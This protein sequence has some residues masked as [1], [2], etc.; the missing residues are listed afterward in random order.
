MGTLAFLLCLSLQEEGFRVDGSPFL[1]LGD[2]VQLEAKCIPPD[3]VVVWRLADGPVTSIETRPALSPSGHTVKGTSVLTVL[4]TGAADAEF[5]FSVTAERKGIRVATTEV[6]LRAGALL[7]IKVWCR[8][9][10]NDAGGTR[11][12]NLILDDCQR[13]ALQWNVNGLLRPLGVE[14]TLEAGS[15]LRGPDWWFD[16]QG[17]FQPIVMKDG[18]K[19]NSPSLND[20]ARNDLPGG[21][22]VY[23]VRDLYWEQVREGFEREVTEHELIGV[24]LKEG[25]VMIDDDGD[26]ASLA[27]ELGHALGLEDRKAKNERD[28]LMY[29]VRRDRSDA[30]VTYGEMKDAREGAQ[31]HRRA[32]A[33]TGSA[34]AAPRPP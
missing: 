17:R 8:C 11:R 29:W 33:K 18:K 23:F 16:R 26:A 31:R 5:R 13:Q 7:P 12:R 19:A 22:N 32:W 24:G 10:E 4:S 25:R 2:R 27:H 6:K 9:V 15:G 14:V 3:T 28:R 30:Q 21:I 1:A 34:V 20:V